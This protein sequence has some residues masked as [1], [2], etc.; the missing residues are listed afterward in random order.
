MTKFQRYAVYYAPPRGGALE[1]FGAAWLG[2]DVRIGASVSYPQIEGLPAPI[3]ELTA[4]PRKYG[5][6]G[7]LKPPF[8]LADGCTPA[9]LRAGLER[10]AAEVSA[11]ALERLV[12]SRLGGF[13]ALTPEG[14]TGPL[15]RLACGVVEALEGYRA[16][17]SAAALAKRPAAGLSP[18]QEAL[19]TR[20]G[21]PYVFDQFRFHMTLTGRLDGPVADAV[22]AR[23][24]AH[25]AP[26]LAE[27]VP[28]A[29]LALFGEDAQGRFHE[30]D[31]VPLA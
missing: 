13:V 19:L 18:R 22:R 29:D 16:P 27:P 14:D 26:I 15:S 4:T 2:W 1:A 8:V 17:L 21:Y 28:V 24:E 20:F 11:F 3:S 9:D 12:V 5:F 25:L 6:H 23:L 30:I 7:T 31:R 10:F